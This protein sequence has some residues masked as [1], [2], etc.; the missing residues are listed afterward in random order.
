V[1]VIRVDPIND[2]RDGEYDEKYVGTFT[3][4]YR[5]QTNDPLDGPLV[6]V[7]HASLPQLYGAYS[8]GNDSLSNA[9]CIAKTP[10]PDGDSRTSWIVTCRFSTNALPQDTN[11]LFD[12]IKVSLGFDQFTK[13]ARADVDGNPVANSMGDVFDP[14][15]EIDDSRP[16]YRVTRNESYINESLVADMKDSVNA[17]AWRGFMPRCVKCKSIS[18]GELQ[19][20]NGTDYYAVVY[21]FHINGDTWD[22]KVLN[23]GRRYVSGGKVVS[24]P[25]DQ[26][27]VVID[28]RTNQRAVNYAESVV[29][30][31]PQTPI[32]YIYVTGRLYKERDFG[33]FNL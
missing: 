27:P 9:L 1:A 6:V 3:A 8:V 25:K 31:L 30:G 33:V 12:P 5:V 2:G 22:F 17:N 21:E 7:N 24:I 16:V 4:A 19:T 23:R 11:P 10:R 29:T 28:W 32:E 26:D 18:P 20:R 13:V 14:P 15:I